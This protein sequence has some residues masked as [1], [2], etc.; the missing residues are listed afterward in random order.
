MSYT[1]LRDGIVNQ[2][3]M[4]YCHY[5]Y[6][7]MQLYNIEKA[8]EK[9]KKRGYQSKA[10]KQLTDEEAEKE[11]M[12]SIS[13]CEDKMEEVKRFFLSDWY[14]SLVDHKIDGQKIFEMTKEKSVDD[15]VKSAISRLQRITEKNLK[16]KASQD[17]IEFFY[18]LK[19]FLKSDYL[20]KLVETPAEEYLKKIEKYT[21]CKFVDFV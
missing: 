16:S 7:I 12:A 19:N 8:I 4:D 21:E 18:E 10:K 1:D 14:D 2:A 13:K 17:S 20:I 6:R 11:R 3:V 15:L 9:I 5:V